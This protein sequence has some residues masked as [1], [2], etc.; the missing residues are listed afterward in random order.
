[1]AKELDL[2]D[3][4]SRYVYYDAL[5]YIPVKDKNKYWAAQVL[6]FNKTVGKHLVNPDEAKFFRDLE[7]GKINV[8]DYKKIIEPVLPDG[9]G[10]EAEYFKSNWDANPIFIHLQ[11]IQDAELKKIPINIVCKA[12]DEFSMQEQQKENARIIGMKQMRNFINEMNANFGFRKLKEDEDPFEFINQM[13]QMASSPQSPTQE[14]ISTIVGSIK[15]SI[16]TND[17]LALYNEYIYK[18]GAEIGIEM[19]IK[20][21]MQVINRWSAISAKIIP[22]IQNFN[23]HCIEQYTT[24]TTGEPKLSWLDPSKVIISDFQMN[25]LSDHTFWLTEFDMSFGEFVRRFGANLTPKQLEQ[26][27]I[28]N[29]SFHG[30]Q[31]SYDRLTVFQ[32]NAAKVRVGYMEFETQ[33]MDVYTKYI[34]EG[35][36]RFKKL[37]PEEHDYAPSRLGKKK[38]NAERVEK[39][40]N[41]WYKLYYT[42]L[43]TTGYN[44]QNVSFKDQAE[45]IFEFDLL[46]DQQREKGDDRRYSKS[47]LVGYKDRRMSFA[48]IV[49]TY[50]PWMNLLWQQFQ[51]DIAN[52]RPD[53]VIWAKEVIEGMMQYID[54]GQKDKS[55]RVM[56]YIKMLHQTGSGISSVVDKDGNPIDV[57]PFVKTS[58]NSLDTAANRLKLMAEL[59]QLMTQALGISPIAEGRDPKPRQN[60]GGITAALES[61]SNSRYY[62]E[63]AYLSTVKN[64]AER[65]LYY[66]KD[67]VD[68]GENSKRFKDLIDII[69][70]PNAYALLTLKDVP[71]HKLHLSVEN[72]MTEEMKARILQLADSMAAAGQLSPDIVIFLSMIENAKYAYAI[73]SIKIKAAQRKAAQ[74]SQ[75]Q[76]Q[77]Q[78]EDKMFENQLKLEQIKATAQGNFD[79]KQMAMQWEARITQL[80]EDLKR[81]GQLQKISAANKN[82]VEQDVVN[83][84]LEM[85]RENT[86]QEEEVGEEK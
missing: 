36:E 51:N 80:E 39:H 8:A 31:E 59:Y 41:V 65:L 19:A 15:T 68:E 47:S 54:T 34:Y 75:I 79:I 20:E 85:R 48:R 24:L 21:Y 25:D 64:I 38:Y 7:V 77:L 71:L 3:K 5:H 43:D 11:N 53:G 50:M 23:T 70:R 30:I 22:D 9:T 40:Y 86:Q 16:E 12:S 81:E 72:L 49:H 13:E 58:L 2:I 26:I 35:N 6:F 37:P 84:T 76:A 18:N 69:G 33:N 14:Q 57:T 45:L 10:G 83:H 44:S 42:P 56:E 1:V 66:I 32:R 29:R 4:E 67:V 62:L 73:L 74:E 55:K 46:Q 60:M 61:G 78:K 52:S 17:E 63:E 28:K 82:K 27:F